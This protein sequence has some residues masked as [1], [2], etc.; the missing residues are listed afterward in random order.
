MIL[1]EKLSE[2]LAVLAAIPPSAQA[3]GVVF[4]PWISLSEIDRIL[5]VIQV[6]PRRRRS[7][8]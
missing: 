2:A 6:R 5:A 1:N 7:R 4:S 3:P 8:C